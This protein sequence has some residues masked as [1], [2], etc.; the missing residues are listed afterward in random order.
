MARLSEIDHK[1]NLETFCV[2]KFA[3]QCLVRPQY[4]FKY[5]WKVAILFP[6]MALLSKSISFKI[7]FRYLPTTSAAGGE[8][9]PVGFALFATGL[10]VPSI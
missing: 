3:K 5:W 9:S 7:F 4:K 10:A 8:S 6:Q 1:L 2:L